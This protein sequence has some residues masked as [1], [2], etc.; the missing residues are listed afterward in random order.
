[1][2]SEY[3]GFWLYEDHP[4]KIEGFLSFPYNPRTDEF[5]QT[6]RLSDISRGHNDA[7]RIS[8]EEFNAK[9]AE[10]RHEWLIHNK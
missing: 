9:C 8:E 1:M 4:I 10:L 5:V 7:R 2:I 3:E 6:Y